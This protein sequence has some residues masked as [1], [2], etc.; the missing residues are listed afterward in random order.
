MQQVNFRIEDDEKLILQALAKAKGI[1]IAELSKELIMKEIQSIRVD[2]A[3]DL[4]KQGMIGFKR[5]WRISGLSYHEFLNEW[6]SRG[7]EE[8]ISEEAQEKEIQDA[9]VIDWEKYRRDL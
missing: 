4:L 6:S 8:S 9:F 3:F 5:C 1:S 7:A 2:F